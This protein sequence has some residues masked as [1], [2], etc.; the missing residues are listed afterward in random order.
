MANPAAR[1][2]P[3]NPCEVERFLCLAMQEGWICGRWEFDLLLRSFPQGCFTMSDGNEAIG[4][5]TSIR[6]GTSGWIG[7]LLVHEKARGLGI[8]RSL[9]QSAVVAL[10]E[11]GAET[12]WLTAS[13]AGKGIY[14]KMGFKEIDSISRWRGQG[15]GCLPLGNAPICLEDMISADAAAWG[16]RR[17]ALL[18]TVTKRGIVNA[19]GRG[20][21]VTQ[22]WPGSKQLG[23]WISSREDA[24][25]LLDQVL[26]LALEENGSPIFIDVPD[27]NEHSASI[28]SSRGFVIRGTTTLMYRGKRPNYRPERIYALASMGSMG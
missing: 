14:E 15:G 4:F 19:H 2:M 17:D 16:D 6:Y 5:V 23:P 1:L 11:A 27:R 10:E 25:A 18:R 8:G 13:R 28:L 7:N 24:R 20:F 3:F 22:P 26:A 9:V 21:A 12:L